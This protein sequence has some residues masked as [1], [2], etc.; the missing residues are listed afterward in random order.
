MFGS[1]RLLKFAAKRC[2]GIAWEVYE[3]PLNVLVGMSDICNAGLMVPFNC[4][5]YSSLCD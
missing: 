1:D 2:Q 4:Q 3:H 5:V